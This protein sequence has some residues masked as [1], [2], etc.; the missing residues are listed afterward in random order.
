MT[1]ADSELDRAG[2]RNVRVH[3]YVRDWADLT[4]AARIEV[5]SA[6]DDARL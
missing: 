6:S 3:E 1:G 4:G 5:I 2:L